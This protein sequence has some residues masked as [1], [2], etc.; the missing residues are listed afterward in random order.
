[1]QVTYQKIMTKL[2]RQHATNSECWCAIVPS[3]KTDTKA[4]NEVQMPECTIVQSEKTYTLA[5]V[6]AAAVRSAACSQ[7]W[8]GAHRCMCPVLPDGNDAGRK[9]TREITAISA[10]LVDLVAYLSI[11][12]SASLK[13]KLFDETSIFLLDETRNKSARLKLT[14]SSTNDFCESSSKNGKIS[15]ALTPSCQFVLR[16]FCSTYLKYCAC[17]ENWLPGHTKCCTYHAKS[18]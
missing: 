3:E 15:A 17:H 5:C 12:L 6:L 13:M 14:T 4:S 11:C 2:L 7:Q 18:S 16:F 8:R 10:T 1:M 9:A